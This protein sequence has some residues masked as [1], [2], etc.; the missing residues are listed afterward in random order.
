M[1]TH[2]K[3][4]LTGVLTDVSLVSEVFCSK[5]NK[6]KLHLYLSA[7]GPGV[8]LGMHAAVRGQQQE[9]VLVLFFHHVPGMKLRLSDLAASTLTSQLAH[10]SEFQMF[11]THFTLS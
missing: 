8:V 9:S 10:P 4:K 6:N 2:S 7:Y 11:N 1:G 3:G 5:T